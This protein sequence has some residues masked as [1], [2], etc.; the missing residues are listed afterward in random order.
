MWI[1]NED[2]GALSDDPRNR[3]ELGLAVTA[4]CVSL[5]EEVVPEWGDELHALLSLDQL[6]RIQALGAPTLSAHRAPGS[7]IERGLGL[8][9]RRENI[10]VV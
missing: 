9:G 8:C 3:V 2:R 6:G 7:L 5:R 4:E 10:L 1:A